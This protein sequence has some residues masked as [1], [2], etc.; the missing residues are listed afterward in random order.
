MTP[1]DYLLFEEALLEILLESFPGSSRWDLDEDDTWRL[2]ELARQ[3]V[4]DKHAGF[5]TSKVLTDY[6]RTSS[7][8]N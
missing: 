1:S 6:V 2:H 7:L 3:R 5:H 8:P 4:S